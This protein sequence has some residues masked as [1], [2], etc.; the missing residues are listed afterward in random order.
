MPRRL[1][2]RSWRCKCLMA[3]MPG[4][5][6]CHYRAAESSGLQVCHLRLVIDP[7]DND[8]FLAPVELERFAQL[9]G[10]RHECR[11]STGAALV[12]GPDEVRHTG[13]A[14][15]IALALDLPVQRQPRA[16]FLLRTQGIGP[17]RLLQRRVE[18]RQLPRS[19]RPAVPR[20][21]LRRRP[22]PGPDGVAR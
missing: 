20:L 2:F 3:L 21:L 15:D 13:I 8:P 11:G 1:K 19:R 6:K 10:Q 17:Q 9:E 14:A 22:Q 16:P 5:Q 12:P 18:R 4:R 7:A